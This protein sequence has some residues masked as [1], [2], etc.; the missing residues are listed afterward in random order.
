MLQPIEILNH[1][2][3]DSTTREKKALITKAMG[4]F[5]THELAGHQLVNGILHSS[6][7]NNRLA[8]RIIDP[9]CGDGRLVCWLLETMVANGDWQNSTMEITLWD[10]D[11]AAL[12][13]AEEKVMQVSQKLKLPLLVNASLGNTFERALNYFG[14]FDIVITN[15]PWEVLKPDRREL[16]KLTKREAQEYINWLKQQDKLLTRLY[17]LSQPKRKFSGWGTNL[18]RCGTELALRLTASQGACGLVSPASLL[19]DQMTEKLRHWI[20]SDHVIHELAYY[21]AEAKLFSKVDQSCITLV[22][23]PGQDKQFSPMLTVYNRQRQVQTRTVLSLSREE[24]EAN[25]LI[26]PIH[27]G[28]E[29]RQLFKR[30][31]TLPTFGEL[32][33][34]DSNALWAG[35]E[36]D[37]TGH[38]HFLGNEGNYL[39]L[40][41]RMI[42]RFGIVEQPIKYVRNDGPRIPPSANYHRIAWRDVSRPSQ[43]RRLHATLIPP[44]WVTGNSLHVAYFR[45]CDLERLK[46]LLAVINSL[47]FEFQL[48]VYLATSHISLS[49]VRKAR[50][51]PLTDYQLV[52]RL[53]K[54]VDQCLAGCE[55]SWIEIEIQ[56]AQ[57]YGLER[58]D[59]KLLLSAFDKLTQAE[60]NAL[61]PQEN[62]VA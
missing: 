50:I 11:E 24:M 57:A 23:S 10:I 1:S 4:H 13:L 5:Y 62:E 48:R 42:Q 15:P 30:W 29:Q 45:D 14:Q 56:V 44:G 33:G 21:P 16:D 35:R 36:L 34:R 61:L 26:L 20:L 18:A 19:A 47:V 12:Y 40:K 60:I 22:A 25:G 31:R 2:A 49:S 43:K 6:V 51:P 28:G 38:K 32:E 53:A 3:Q 58:N 27:F 8:I 55:T 9:F 52:A 39:F 41:G 59:F 7:C 37:E 17:P 46:A 54:L